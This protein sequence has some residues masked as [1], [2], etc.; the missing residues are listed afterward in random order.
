MG[1]DTEGNP[2]YSDQL[3]PIRVPRADSEG[4]V[5]YPTDGEDGTSRLTD[6]VP[7][8]DAAGTDEDAATEYEFIAYDSFTIDK[9]TGQISVT[10]KGSDRNVV[11]GVIAIG[12]VTNPNGVTA[13]S[14]TYY[15][16][17]A[18][19]GDL[20]ITLMGGIEQEMKIGHNTGTT[21]TESG[22][23]QP[24]NGV[25]AMDD[26]GSALYVNGS[27]FG[28]ADGDDV[29]L[30]DGS[31]VSSSGTTVLVTGGLELSKTDLATEI[32]NMITTQRGYQANTRIITVTDSMLEEL[33]NMKR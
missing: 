9:N 26:G 10:L 7:N 27:L 24:V 18:G 22:S 31:R 4:R 20:S 5:M 25:S 3:V 14:N 15:K 2:V 30:P 11:I 8:P 17:G 33:V 21:Y 16:C 28:G 32:V 13:D 1:V 23:L 12:N 19:A 29:T 6:A